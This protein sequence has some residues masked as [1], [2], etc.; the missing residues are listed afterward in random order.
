M[1]AGGSAA[2]VT[3]LSRRLSSHRPASRHIFQPQRGSMRLLGTMPLLALCACAAQQ[4]IVA[5]HAQHACALSW[6]Q[7]VKRSRCMSHMCVRLGAQSW[8]MSGTIHTMP[9]RLS[10][11]CW[12]YLQV[13]A[14]IM[15]HPSGGGCISLAA[16]CVLV[17]YSTQVSAVGVSPQSPSGVDDTHRP[18][19][20]LQLV[21]CIASASH[22]LQ[23]NPCDKAKSRHVSRGLTC[24]QSSSEGS[25][26]GPSM[27]SAAQ[28]C[29]RCC[30]PSVSPPCSSPSSSG[31]ASGAM[32]P[33]PRPSAASF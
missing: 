14:H 28:R 7:T 1:H 3:F 27:A 5:V 9:L 10:S 19:Q 24:R 6:Q 31:R 30:S 11:R 16:C 26:G 23:G 15:A 21:M 4:L 13:Q 8:Q 20:V 33:S 18:S 12:P 32:P 2:K 17:A 25:C 22:A 29:A